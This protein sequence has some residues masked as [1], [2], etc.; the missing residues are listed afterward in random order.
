MRLAAAL[1]AIA[2]GTLPV[3]AATPAPAVDAIRLEMLV[4]RIAKLDS[5]V[6]QGV[7][8]AR[9]RRA[10]DAAMQD[11]DESLHTAHAQSQ[12]ELR[13]TYATLTLLW[14]Q[15]RAWHSR[16]GDA[17]QK[18]RERTEEMAWA[19]SKGAR[20]VQESSRAS[21]NAQAVRAA[22]AA[23]LAQ[24]VTKLYFWRLRGMRDEAFERD[25]RESGEN[26]RRLVGSLR[27]A[28][29]PTPEIEAELVNAEG[30]LRFLD[31]AV[32]DLASP[33]SRSR[34]Q[35]FLAKTGDNITESMERAARLYA[36]AP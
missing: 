28:P 26:L 9:S 34:A 2:C 14:S 31:D 18:L 4:E 21:T 16:G 13:D 3:Q 15:F 7:L 20:L 12:G 35:E 5:Q 30:Q 1:C 10:L 24:R 22:N 8:A 6:H 32:R 25:L 23:V 11:F 17:P 29:A 33:A 36:A 19:A 27:A